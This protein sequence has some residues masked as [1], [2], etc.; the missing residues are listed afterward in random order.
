[1]RV[2]GVIVWAVID[3]WVLSYGRRSCHCECAMLHGRGSYFVARMFGEGAG[4]AYP[5]DCWTWVASLDCAVVVVDASAVV[6]I[7]PWAGALC[8]CGGAR[9]GGAV[10]RL[11][12]SHVAAW[13][14]HV[15]GLL[16]A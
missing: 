8:C 9:G 10:W 6:V 15:A 7:V 16:I 2:S 13:C 12:C 5:W 3:E 1:M 14:L 4:E 11:R